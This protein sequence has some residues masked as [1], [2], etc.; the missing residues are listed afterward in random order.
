MTD[1]RRYPVRNDGDREVLLERVEIASRDTAGY[2]LQPIGSQQRNSVRRSVDI[3]DLDLDADLP[4]IA[5]FDRD[6][7]GAVRHRACNSD[8]DGFL[9]HRGRQEAQGKAEAE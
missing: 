4:E 5:L 7:F 6:Q 2:D 8:A 9:S 3:V 1:W